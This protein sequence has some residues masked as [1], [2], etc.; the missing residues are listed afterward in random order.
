MSQQLPVE[1]KDITLEELYARLDAHSS[2]LTDLHEK[3]H[4][5]REERDVLRG[6]LESVQR[7]NDELRE[8]LARLDAR[9]DLLSVI[10]EADKM[11]A[12]QRSVVLIQHL[13]RE[14]ERKRENGRDAKAS[15]DR[16]D[17]ARALQFPDLHRTTIYSDMRRA[18]EMVDDEN[19]LRY[20][21][22]S[23]DKRRLE[24][25]LEAGELPGNVIGRNVNHGGK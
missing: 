9:T 19:V 6:E 20:A 15:V 7:E 11:E 4:D 22:N 16:K 13:K 3:L 23:G 2:Q 8:K 10:E 24:L 18:A 21:K 14:A 25:D 12:K 1:E 5:A 17:A